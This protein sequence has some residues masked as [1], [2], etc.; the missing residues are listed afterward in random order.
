MKRFIALILV[1]IIVTVCFGGCGPDISG[2]KQEAYEEGYRD[3]EIYAE[4]NLYPEWRQSG[5]DDGD[6][7][8]YDEGYSDGY[9]SGY[10]NGF[11]D[12]MSEGWDQAL[13]EYHIKH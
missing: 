8:G 12:G 2:I 9:S 10:A 7:D 4:N 6:R 13:D 11:E 1:I 3:A 5:Y